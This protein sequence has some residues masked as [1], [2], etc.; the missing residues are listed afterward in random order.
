ME[1]LTSLVLE[2]QVLGSLLYYENL[3]YEIE[4]FHI[5][6]DYSHIVHK[7]CFSII[8]D[9]ALKKEKID[10]TILAQR[11]ANIGLKKYEELDL[12]EYLSSLSFNKFGSIEIAKTGC[13]ELSK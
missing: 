1:E 4:N 12:F 9:A 11:L 13:E 6:N 5:D 7:A 8:R 10:S 2:R 3:F